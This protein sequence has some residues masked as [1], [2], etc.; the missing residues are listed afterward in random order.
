MKKALLVLCLALS[1]C[2]VG[3]TVSNTPDSPESCVGVACRK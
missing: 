3:I 2:S 1:G